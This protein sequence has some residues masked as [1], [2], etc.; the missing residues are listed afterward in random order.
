[1]LK[2]GSIVGGKYR[3]QR[4][5]GKGAMAT[6]WAASH[7]TLGRQVAVKCIRPG[8]VASQET[9]ARFLREARIA[10]S[11]RHR[12]IVDI[13]DFGTTEEGMPFMVMELLKGESL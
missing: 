6:V 10:A 2:A 12:F 1:M 9:V 13:F 8:A 4:L 3:L 7:E 5:V 11:I